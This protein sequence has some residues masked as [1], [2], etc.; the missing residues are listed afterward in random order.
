MLEPSSTGF[1]N[2]K[3]CAKTVSL[4]SP[5]T[6]ELWGMGAGSGG[7]DTGLCDPMA[8]HLQC[9][10]EPA[11]AASAASVPA[12]PGTS[13]TYMIC[14]RRLTK[15][16]HSFGWLWLVLDLTNYGQTTVSELVR[17]NLLPVWVILK[18]KWYGFSIVTVRTEIVLHPPFSASV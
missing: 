6:V 9:R 7:G 17:F 14:R 18:K 16:K 1:T 3:P 13:G 4:S 5:W 15:L 2:W 8:W 12:S 10:V 11:T